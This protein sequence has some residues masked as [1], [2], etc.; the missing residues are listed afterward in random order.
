[1]SSAQFWLNRVTFKEVHI[2]ETEGVDMQFSTRHLAIQC[3]SL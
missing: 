3:Q 1:M 2:V